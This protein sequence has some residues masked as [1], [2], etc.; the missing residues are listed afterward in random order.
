[1]LDAVDATPRSRTV[2]LRAELRRRIGDTL[3]AHRT[4]FPALWTPPVHGELAAIMSDLREGSSIALLTTEARV[5]PRRH[6]PGERF[7]DLYETLQKLGDGGMATVWKCRCRDG[8][9]LVA[10]KRITVRGVSAS[11]RDTA[12]REIQVMQSVS[13]AVSRVCCVLVVKAARRWLC[14]CS[15][16]T[17][18]LWVTSITSKRTVGARLCCRWRRCARIYLRASAWFLLRSRCDRAGELMIVMELVEGSDMFEY[19]VQHVR[20][21]CCVFFCCVHTLTC[22]AWHSCMNGQQGRK[23]SEDVCREVVRQVA[24]GLAYLHARGILHR[25]IKVGSGVRRCCARLAM[26]VT[27]LAAG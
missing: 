1:M 16:T 12:L 7:D 8:G 18:A 2:Q 22:A 5:R 26:T 15:L 24:S 4:S 20:C 10:V 11:E 25:D 9:L 27:L 14:G 3:A 21:C 6:E 19:M 13:A 17:R 23:C